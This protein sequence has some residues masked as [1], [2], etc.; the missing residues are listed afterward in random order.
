MP[1]PHDAVSQ[2]DLEVIR[3]QVGQEE[4]AER[5][6]EDEREDA[7]Q[8]PRVRAA[9]HRHRRARRRGGRASVR[10][11]YLP[12]GAASSRPPRLKDGTSADA[13]HPPGSRVR[14][15]RVHARGL[16]SPARALDSRGRGG[17]AAR[18]TRSA[19]DARQWEWR[20]QMQE[21][22]RKR[23]KGDPVS[24]LVQ[25]G[26]VRARHIKPDDWW[27]PRRTRV[28]AG[29]ALELYISRARFRRTTRPARAPPTRRARPNRH[30]HERPDRFEGGDDV[31][32]M[33]RR[34]GARPEED[35][36]CDLVSR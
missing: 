34:G 30:R 16:S 17:R 15:P 11:C 10:A 6:L 19:S 24:D 13:S 20:R 31:R 33:L 26:W 23:G 8:R 22:V 4:P 21:S 2:R 29:N 36:R 14:R 32:R 18:R 3:V 35:G 1:S 12:A 27:V 25:V 9:E 28:K 7:A 5:A